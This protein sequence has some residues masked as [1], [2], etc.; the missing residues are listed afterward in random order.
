LQRAWFKRRCKIAIVASKKKFGEVWLAIAD[1]K[2]RRKGKKRTMR[3]RELN[4]IGL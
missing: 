4:H 3:R 1:E 2:K